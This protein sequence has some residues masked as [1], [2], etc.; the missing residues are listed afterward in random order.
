MSVKKSLSKDYIN[1]LLNRECISDVHT[2]HL[3]TL[4]K[5]RLLDGEQYEGAKMLAGLL[6]QPE[7]SPERVATEKYLRSLLESIEAADTDRTESNCEPPERPTS[8]EQPRSDL[9]H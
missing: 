4:D 1:A 2:R 5:W 7:G 3:E 8:D 6:K 9:E